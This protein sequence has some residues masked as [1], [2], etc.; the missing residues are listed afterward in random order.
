[1]GPAGSWRCR[2]WG[3]GS[4]AAACPVWEVPLRGFSLVRVVCFVAENSDT[5][6]EKRKSDRTLRGDLVDWAGVF[7]G[8]ARA[9]THTGGVG[10]HECAS[11]L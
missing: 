8:H 11:R 6:G 10:A 7:M 4:R 5:R 2:A 9:V 3:A 1:M